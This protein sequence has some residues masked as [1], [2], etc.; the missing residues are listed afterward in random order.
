M[1]ACMK[2]MTSHFVQLYHTNQDLCFLSLI[3]RPPPFLFFG[4]I[5]HG[6]GRARKT[7]RFRVLYRTQN[8]RTINGGGLGMSLRPCMV[9]ACSVCV[10]VCVCACVCVCVWKRGASTSY[11]STIYTQC[12]SD[13]C[14]TN[15][16]WT[17]SLRS[18]VDQ[19][20]KN[21]CLACW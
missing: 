5:I 8:R 2:T 18:Q 19:K 12:R 6:S 7:G 10:C 15:C 21:S 14:T 20:L 11:N 16:L 3:P 17:S 1:A 9:I 4:S 13:H